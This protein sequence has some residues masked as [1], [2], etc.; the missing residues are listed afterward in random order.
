MSVP[1]RNGHVAEFHAAP[2]VTEQIDEHVRGLEELLVPLRAER[3]QLKAQLADLQSRERGIAHAIG[4]LRGH[5]APA[6]KP[7]PKPSAGRPGWTPSEERLKSLFELL[8]KESEPISPTQLAAK[9]EG[10]GVETATKG[11]KVL[12][13][14][15]L[16][17]V[18]A[19]LRGG[20]SSYAV[21]PGAEWPS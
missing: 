12:R 9:S 10:L 1:G 11:F 13:E 15:E 2:S 17:R 16:V 21:M 19:N 4:A 20:G 8:A 7:K 14:R 6:A 3:D 5:G 18:A